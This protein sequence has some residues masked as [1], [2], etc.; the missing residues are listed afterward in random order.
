MKALN[1]YFPE[2]KSK[3]IKDESMIQIAMPVSLKNKLKKQLKK[4][5]RNLKQFIVASTK[6]YLDTNATKTKKSS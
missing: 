3:T 2:K 5:K 4:D 6:F 1:D